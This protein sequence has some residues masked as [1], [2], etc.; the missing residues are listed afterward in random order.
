MSGRRHPR[1]APPQRRRHVEAQDARRAGAT[2]PANGIREAG[3][4]LTVNVSPVTVIVLGVR[5]VGCGTGDPAPVA[6]SK[7]LWWQGQTIWLPSTDATV[8]PWCGH[9]ASNALNVPAVGWVTTVWLSAKTLPP[10]TGISDVGVPPP[11]TSPADA[12]ASRT[13]RRR[14]HVGGLL[15]AARAPAAATTPATRGG[16]RVGR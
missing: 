5:P 16:R 8:Q 15:Q 6:A 10:P 12:A 4:Q 1:E 3:A 14:R 13:T 11:P 2:A 7:W 9:T